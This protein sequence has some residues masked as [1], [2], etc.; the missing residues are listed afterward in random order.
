MAGVAHSWL[1]LQ[2]FLVAVLYCFANKEVTSLSLSQHLLPSSPTHRV[3]AGRAQP[4][5]S[6]C[7]LPSVAGEVRD[8][9]EVAALEARPPSALLCPVRW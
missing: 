6:P 2:G 5:I 7:S 3:P 4:G 9:E 8:E 1:S